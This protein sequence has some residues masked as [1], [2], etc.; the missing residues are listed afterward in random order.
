M[1]DFREVLSHCDL[2]DIG[3][4]GTPWTYI[5]IIGME[6]QMCTCALIEALQIMIGLMYILML[7]FLIYVH[8]DRTIWFSFSDYRG[9]ETGAPA[10]RP[11][12]M[13]S[14]GKEQRA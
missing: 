6:G 3:F 14:C 9:R 10:A 12:A 4:S 5:I 11:F 8:P 1:L 2:Q 13:K 7:I